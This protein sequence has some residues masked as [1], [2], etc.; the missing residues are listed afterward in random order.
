M[1]VYVVQYD[2][3]EKDFDGTL[4]EAFGSKSEALKRYRELKSATDPE[5][6]HVGL[7]SERETEGQSFLMYGIFKC[8]IPTDKKGLIDWLT[9]AQ[10]Q[11]PMGQRIKVGE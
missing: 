9:N 11:T 1:K 2:L 4:A 3:T 5:T 7:D 10:I 6:I 8:D